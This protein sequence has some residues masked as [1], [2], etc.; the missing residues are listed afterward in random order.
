MKLN[1]MKETFQKIGVLM[2]G[3][4][5]FLYENTMIAVSSMLLCAR[6]LGGNSTQA[7]DEAE[8]ALDH[9]NTRY[10]VFEEALEARKRRDNDNIKVMH[11]WDYDDVTFR[12]LKYNGDY[13]VY[14]TEVATPDEI[15]YLDLVT[16]PDIETLFGLHDS[17]HPVIEIR[18]QFK[19]LNDKIDEALEAFHSI[20]EEVLDS[21][22]QSINML[23]SILEYDLYSKKELI[24]EI[25]SN[26]TKMLQGN[27]F[28]DPDELL[29]SMMEFNMID[30]V[31]G[32]KAV[33]HL[34]IAR[35]YLT[36]FKYYKDKD[37][38]ILKELSSRVNTTRVLVSCFGDKVPYVGERVIANFSDYHILDVYYS[39]GLTFYEIIK[40]SSEGIFV[41]VEYEFEKYLT[42]FESMS[43]VKEFLN[44]PVEMMDYYKGSYDVEDMI[45]DLEDVKD[46][47]FELKVACQTAPTHLLLSMQNIIEELENDIISLESSISFKK[48]FMENLE[49]Q[50]RL[51]KGG[52]A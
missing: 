34:S 26:C 33:A 23:V 46:V 10:R 2:Q 47:L 18:N 19:L 27:G 41:V 52:I 30:G 45:D 15:Y 17:K 32:Y 22:P 20:D 4:N 6:D 43:E 1:N 9:Y 13:S 21:M 37:K 50:V 24:N 44:S 42:V 40:S 3:D 51:I 29:K 8:E 28:T 35:Q 25:I 16:I 31:H 39:N 11:Q 12:D 5:K 48:S 14:F 7:M 36:E 38:E 49:E